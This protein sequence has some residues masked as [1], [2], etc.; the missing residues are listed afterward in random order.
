MARHTLHVAVITRCS[1]T[2]RLMSSLCDPAQICSV[3][4]AHVRLY[5]LLT[6]RGE[7]SSSGRANHNNNGNAEANNDANG[8]G[9]F[10]YKD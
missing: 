2:I 5:Q 4:V 10:L 7:L 8:N 1:V 9:K 6:V 3:A